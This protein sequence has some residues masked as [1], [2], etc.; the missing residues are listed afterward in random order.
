[1]IDLLEPHNTSISLWTALFYTQESTTGYAWYNYDPIIEYSPEQQL[2]EV[3]ES[4][5]EQGIRGAE[6]SE[7]GIAAVVLRSDGMWQV[8]NPRS[9]ETDAVICMFLNF[10]DLAV[11]GIGIAM[12][13]VRH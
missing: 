6:S 7:S 4:A 3:D 13:C 8:V 12:Q 1:M 9:V 11:S 2:F 10:T 5:S